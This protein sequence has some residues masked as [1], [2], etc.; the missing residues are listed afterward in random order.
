MLELENF[1]PVA[2][3][4]SSPRKDPTCM[5][6]PPQKFSSKGK[7]VPVSALIFP[8]AET[9]MEGGL[10]RTLNY[11]SV[12]PT[13]DIP[14]GSSIAAGERMH[15]LVK[16]CSFSF[17]FFSFCFCDYAVHVTFLDS[18]SLRVVYLL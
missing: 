17:F 9:V 8:V 6:L 14:D 3:E 13:D 15:E 2:M 5:L 16:V 4:S 11:V 12:F 18:G 10:R 7:P 1:I